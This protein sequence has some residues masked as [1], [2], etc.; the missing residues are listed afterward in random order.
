MWPHSKTKYKYKFLLH[1]LFLWSSLYKAMTGT[2][3]ILPLQSQLVCTAL[4][5]WSS[6]HLGPWVSMEFTKL[7]CC[8]M[9]ILCTSFSNPTASHISHPSETNAVEQNITTFSPRLCF[10]W[11]SQS[12]AMAGTCL[13]LTSSIT[14]GL[15]SLRSQGLVYWA[16]SQHGSSRI[17]LSFYSYWAVW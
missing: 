17:W 1:Y 11:P 4:K 8:H 14:A 10:L 16:G 5:S 9:F 7:I 15:Q 6:K 2:C 12:K 3:L 13:I